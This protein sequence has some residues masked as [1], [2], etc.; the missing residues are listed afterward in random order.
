MTAKIYTPEKFSAWIGGYS[1][2]SYGVLWKN[3][4]LRYEI[5]EHGFMPSASGPQII[6]PSQRK[7]MWFWKK[8]EKVRIWEWEENYN[9]TN[10]VDGTS[11]NVDIA[12]SGKILT[13]GGRNAYPYFDDN[14]DVF[15]YFLKA[16]STLLGGLTFC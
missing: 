11:W 14:E 4:S 1:G 3:D 10:I 9:C 16:V 7:W 15:G 13:S 5:Q 6:I 2:N 8:L 12:Y